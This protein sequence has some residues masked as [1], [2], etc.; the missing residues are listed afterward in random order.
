MAESQNLVNLYTDEGRIVVEYLSRP[1]QEG[2][3]E[4]T[5]ESILAS[6]MPPEV[7]AKNLSQVILSLAYEDIKDVSEVL[8]SI[9]KI[10]FEIKVENDRI[11]FIITYDSEDEKSEKFAKLIAISIASLPQWINTRLTVETEKLLDEIKDG[12]RESL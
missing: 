6:D 8:N 4:K 5:L 1:L 9:P 11:K 3:L 10:G 7:A 2:E 12:K